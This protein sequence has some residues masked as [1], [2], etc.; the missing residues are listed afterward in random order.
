MMKAL[1]QLKMKALSVLKIKTAN[2][3]TYKNIEIY[4]KKQKFELQGVIQYALST[5]VTTEIF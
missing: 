4:R 2:K 1:T 3:K 5:K